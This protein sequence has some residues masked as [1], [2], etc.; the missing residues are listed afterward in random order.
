MRPTSKGIAIT[1][2]DSTDLTGVKQ[3][4]V[5]GA[6]NLAVRLRRDPATTLTFIAPPVGTVLDVEV[7]R[8][9]AATTATN[10]LGFY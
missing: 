8:V 2:S 1:P 5:G 7:T 10:L 9:M 3:I 6:G 4:Y